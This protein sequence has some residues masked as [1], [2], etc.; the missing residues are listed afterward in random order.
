MTEQSTGDTLG[1]AAAGGRLP[2]TDDGAD[3]LQGTTDSS[4][5][6]SA[7]D[8]ALAAGADPD[9]DNTPEGALGYDL[10]SRDT[11][12]QGSAGTDQPDTVDDDAIASGAD[13]DR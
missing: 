3:E 13:P 10:T 12:G 1:Q 9:D 7:G 8:D 2:G 11:D 4:R 5:P 6:D